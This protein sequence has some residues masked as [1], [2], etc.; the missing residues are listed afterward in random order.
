MTCVFKLADCPKKCSVCQVARGG[1]LLLGLLAL[2]SRTGG[3]QLSRLD[4]CTKGMLFPQWLQFCL[5]M[6][7]SQGQDGSLV[8]SC[9]LVK[10]IFIGIWC[11]HMFEQ[12]CIFAHYFAELVFDKPNT[13]LFEEK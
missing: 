6:F 12:D 4:G 5:Y 9:E 13:M 10:I 1:I 8:F 3:V 11:C 2:C 7:C